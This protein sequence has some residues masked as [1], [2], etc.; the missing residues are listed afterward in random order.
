M[1]LW[2]EQYWQVLASIDVQHVCSMNTSISI[3]II[4]ILLRN[5]ATLYPTLYTAFSNYS[6]TR[7]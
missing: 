2:S 3:K 4:E 6:Q 7:N 1:V 5:G